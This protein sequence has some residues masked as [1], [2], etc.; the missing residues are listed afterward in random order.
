[1]D[2]E[3]V[4]YLEYNEN[5]ILEPLGFQKDIDYEERRL[6]KKKGKIVLDLAP[7]VGVRLGSPEQLSYNN[8]FYKMRNKI[9]EWCY[10]KWE[11]LNEF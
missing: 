11:V 5:Q 4:W 2:G 1:M 9:P 8:Y 10:A 3:L 6:F 7:K